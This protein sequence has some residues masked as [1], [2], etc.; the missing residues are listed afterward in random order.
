MPYQALHR[1]KRKLRIG[2]IVLVLAVAVLLITGGITLTANYSQLMSPYDSKIQ[3]AE[4]VSADM[5]LPTP[6]P[7]PAPTY[8]PNDRKPSCAADLVSPYNGSEGKRAFLTFDD[9]PTYLTPEILD[10]LKSKEVKATFFTLGQQV[11]ANPDT[12]K[13][14]FEEGHTIANHSYS[15]DYPYIYKNVD[16][17]KADLDRA[18]A[19]ISQVIGENNY[20]KLFRFPGGTFRE[21]KKA[22]YREYLS[23]NGYYYIDWNC[24]NGDAEAQN[25]PADK[26]L[27]NVKKTSQGSNNIVV[28]MHDAATKRTTVEALPSIIDYLRS[29]GYSFHTLGEEIENQ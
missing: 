12:V 7:K 15:H 10:I 27:A 20:V 23:Q 11:E 25:V 16:N 18:A 2:R 9:G 24:M 29:E 6:T 19:A 13:R 4:Y 22:P 17:F 1:R 28:L 3:G 14:E 26:L 5:L 8:G 21:A